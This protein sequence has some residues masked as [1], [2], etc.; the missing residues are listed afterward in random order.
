[1]VSAVSEHDMIIKA[2]AN[3]DA[4]K[5]AMTMCFHARETVA[6]WRRVIESM[7]AAQ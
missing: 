5:V 3:G 4:A 7:K 6:A 2:I 1:M